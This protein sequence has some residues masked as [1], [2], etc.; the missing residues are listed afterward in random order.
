MLLLIKV[1]KCKGK[2]KTHHQHQLINVV[3]AVA[4]AYIF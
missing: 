1:K 4:Q 3:G 2:Q